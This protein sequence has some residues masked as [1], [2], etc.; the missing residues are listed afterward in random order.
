MDS[1]R[2]TAKAANEAM[3]ALDSFTG[4]D[5]A[6]AMDRRVVDLAAEKALQMHDRSQ[7]IAAFQRQL[8]P[9]LMQ[10]DAFDA[11]PEQPATKAQLTTFRNR[12]AEAK[13][14]IAG[15]AKSGVVRIPKAGGGT[16][17]LFVD[18]SFLDEAAKLL[19]E[20]ETKLK[21]LRDSA[22][23]DLRRR[24]V[25]KDVAF[26]LDRF[27]LAEMMSFFREKFRGANEYIVLRSLT[28]FAD[29]E[30]QPLPRILAPFDWEKAKADIR[31][32]VEELA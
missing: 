1:L 5:F 9:V 6:N 13:N 15:A 17:E 16:R 8:A 21:K 29:A 32:A 18:R 24:F 25:R 20:A 27:S 10:L 23:L 31:S 30:T 22:A 26:L 2:A 4:E 14:A 12:I 7:A 28:Y 11:H 19:G 3:R